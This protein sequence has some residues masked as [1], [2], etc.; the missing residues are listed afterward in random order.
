MATMRCPECGLDYPL[1]ATRCTTC[2]TELT[3]ELA[4][5][6]PA[7]TATLPADDAPRS[8]HHDE[9]LDDEDD[10]VDTDGEDVDLGAGSEQTTYE[11]DEWSGPDRLMLEQ[12]LTGAGIT[13]VWS[14]SDLVVRSEDEEVV[15][16]LVEQVR[17]TDQPVLDPE[18]DK[19]VFEVSDWSAA[20][21]GTL[22]DGLVEQGIPYEFDVEG[23]LVV[24][25]EAEDAVESLLDGIE[26]GEPNAE[27]EADDDGEGDDDGIETAGILSDLF[28]AC[29]RLKKNATDHEGVLGVVS[30]AARLEGR[31]LPF[32]YVPSVWEEIQDGATKLRDD[33]DDD[34]VSDQELEDRAGDLWA[35]LRQYV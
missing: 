30:A 2:D 7:D 25:A 34:D 28:V 21:L 20:Q 13:R 15:D 9:D 16:E 27:D 24:L 4:A 12:L 1:S 35:M 6:A 19:L 10:V 31:A 5:D 18:A 8:A 14:G 26:F 33:L 23:D 3:E 22:T 11:L 32:G 17:A 29:D